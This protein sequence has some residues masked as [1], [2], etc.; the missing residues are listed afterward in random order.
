MGTYRGPDDLDDEARARVRRELL[1]RVRPHTTTFGD[2]LY[3]AMSLLA[4]PAPHLVR[5]IVSLA[6]VGSVVGAATVAS[7]DSLPDEPL[8]GLKVASEQLRLALVAS[9]EDRAAVELSM[10]D[11]RLAEAERLAIEGRGSDAI[12]AAGA[13]GAHLANAAA[14]LAGPEQNDPRSSVV[15][16]QLRSRLTA[17]Q[18]SAEDVAARVA[19]P[20]SSAALRSIASVPPSASAGAVAEGIAA[21]AAAVASQ[22]AAVA[23]RAVKSEPPPGRLV[24][25]NAPAAGAQRGAPAANDAKPGAPKSEDPRAAPP[26]RA[27]PAKAEPA[28]AAEAARQA[29]DK[30]KQEADNARGA[31]EKAK[32]DAKDAKEKKDKDPK[33]APPP[34][35]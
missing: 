10:A 1:S 25:A 19:D 5:A 12:A 31:A 2:R 15:I 28:K 21:H 3:T 35:R 9:P 34:R 33:G 23:Q 22:A 32:R 27:E 13:Y 16:G 24:P 7:A 4:T 6:L 29:V 26:A 17:Q 8:Y 30:T 11:H 14:A 18:R 20:D